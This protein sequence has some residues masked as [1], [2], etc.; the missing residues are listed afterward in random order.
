M[1]VQSNPDGDPSLQG[2]PEGNVV[3][4]FGGIDVL[5]GY[6]AIF[7]PPEKC[8]PKGGWTYR[9]LFSAKA[10]FGLPDKDMEI[11]EVKHG[12]KYSEGGGWVE[13]EHG[14]VSFFPK[15]KRFTYEGIPFEKVFVVI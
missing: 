10:G 15:N 12:H 5:R 13:T 8:L 3:L 2:V 4:L 9:E 14:N 11:Y 7:G 1:K 6:C